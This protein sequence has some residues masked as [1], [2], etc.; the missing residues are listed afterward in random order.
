MPP[1]CDA[2]QG[3]GSSCRMLPYNC[4]VQ[5]VDF[6]SGRRVYWRRIRKTP[7]TWSSIESRDVMYLSYDRDDLGTRIYRAIVALAL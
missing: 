4:E 2:N 5:I 6:S 3:Q 7:R 1:D